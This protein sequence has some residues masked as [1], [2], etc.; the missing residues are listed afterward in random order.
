[1][2]CV[3]AFLF[4]VFQ[5]IPDS[6]SVAPCS[7]GQTHPSVSSKKPISWPFS[8]KT[9]LSELLGAPHTTGWCRWH[10]CGAG[11]RGITELKTDGRLQSLPY[12]NRASNSLWT[13]KTVAVGRT[14]SPD[15]LLHGPP[16]V[17]LR[18]LP[19]L[20]KD[21][22]LCS[23]MG[24][25]DLSLDMVW[26]T[27]PLSFFGHIFCIEQKGPSQWGKSLSWVTFLVPKFIHLNEA[28]KS[29]IVLQ[30]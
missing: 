12:F 15:F 14:F 23:F 4:F 1:M 20:C 27:D 29:P 11:T 2:G 6:V 22:R 9:A 19:I 25:S 16:I 17:Y 7:H 13:I 30:H 21:W 5:I 3:R 8:N 24:G 26:V 18:L 10:L 28:R